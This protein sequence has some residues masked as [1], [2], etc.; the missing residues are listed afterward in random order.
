MAMCLDLIKRERECTDQYIPM[1][2]DLRVEL[3]KPKGFAEQVATPEART[4][5]IAAAKQEWQADSSPDKARRGCA[6]IAA[7]IPPAQAAKVKQDAE[8]C[9]ARESCDEFVSCIKP[10]Q[11]SFITGR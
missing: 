5:A 2:V 10:M 7:S 9:M 6:F 4:A 11:A 8:Q 1:L 3:D